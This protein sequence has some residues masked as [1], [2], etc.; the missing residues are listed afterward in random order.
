MEES[1]LWKAGSDMDA[2]RIPA[3]SNYRNTMRSNLTMAEPPWSPPD[4][5]SSMKGGCWCLGDPPVSPEM[6]QG[7]ALQQG[8]EQPAFPDLGV[9]RQKQG[10]PSRHHVWVQ[11]VSPVI[12][13]QASNTSTVTAANTCW[14]PEPGGGAQ[15][16]GHKKARKVKVHA[17]RWVLQFSRPAVT[18]FSKAGT[19][20]TGF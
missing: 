2:A 12:S 6:D 1:F 14:P 20:G 4:A 11:R 15:A 9:P 16:L 7:S 8:G 10:T 5:F 19:S 13:L 3:P 18:C 17:V